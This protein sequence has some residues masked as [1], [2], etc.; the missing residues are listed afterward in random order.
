MNRILS[1]ALAAAICAGPAFAD[2][3]RGISPMRPVMQNSGRDANNSIFI[4]G[5]GPGL[6]YSVNYE[7][8]VEDVVGLRAGISYQS[9]SASASSGGSTASASATFVTVPVIAT[10]LGMTS[11][12]HT[13]EVGAGGTMVF[14]SGSAS[15]T[16][17]A[18]SGSGMLPLGTAIIGYRRQPMDGGFQFRIGLEA[19]FGKGLSL[20]NPDPNSFG[21]LP[22]MYMSLGFSL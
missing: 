3:D 9:F 14:A 22:W 7:R 1:I 20:S 6:L 19:L 11:G 8:I 4:E 18:A 10:Y 17:I 21:V 12:N 2:P 16:G 15:G 13:L 5:G